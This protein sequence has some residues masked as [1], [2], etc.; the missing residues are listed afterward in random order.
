MVTGH[1]SLCCEEKEGND[2]G[3]T[4]GLWFAPTVAG[5]VDK[6]QKTGVGRVRRIKELGAETELRR[7]IDAL[8]GKDEGLGH[9]T[10]KEGSGGGM[11]IVAMVRL[12]GTYRMGLRGTAVRMKCHGELWGGG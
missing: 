4:Q 8:E 10:D 2:V 7:S 5:S 6:G 1:F 12:V 9:D 3:Y 11:E